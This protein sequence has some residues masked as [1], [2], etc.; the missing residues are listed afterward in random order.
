[1]TS[2]SE[3]QAGDKK[4]PA[5]VVPSDNPS[6]QKRWA[7]NFYPLHRGAWPT[8]QVD[9]LTTPMGNAIIVSVRRTR[10]VRQATYADG[11]VSP[12]P[13]GTYTEICRQRFY[14][15]RT[16]DLAIVRRWFPQD[17]P[18]QPPWNQIERVL[19]A[20]GRTREAI[21]QYDA[22]TVLMALQ[23]VKQDDALAAGASM[24]MVGQ[25][26]EPCDAGTGQ[27]KGTR[28]KRKPGRPLLSGDTDAKT[29][30]A[31]YN[32]FKASGLGYRAYAEQH[33]LKESDVRR[34]CDRHRKRQARLRRRKTP[35]RA[36]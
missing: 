7:W 26:T 22:P 16:E 18:H 8:R 27:G 20:A 31:T 23:R 1:M 35:R 34:A 13:P 14:L 30:R 6:A 10:P 12:D 29:D 24:L 2:Q 11:S 21:A 32:A 15:P 9:D 19:L 3:S 28:E 17:D 25:A 36:P 4:V 5:A 33:R